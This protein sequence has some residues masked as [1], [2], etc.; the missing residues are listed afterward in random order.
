MFDYTILVM[1]KEQEVKDGRKK[2][3]RFHTCLGS[4][5]KGFRA[6]CRPLIGLDGCYLK[7]PYEGNCNNNWYRCQ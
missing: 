2:F 7:G 3:K 4:P 6:G 1:T 5:K